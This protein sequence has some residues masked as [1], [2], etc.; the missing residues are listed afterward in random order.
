MD[1][2]SAKF[3]DL[4]KFM[5]QLLLVF[6]HTD[7]SPENQ[8]FFSSA[9]IIASVLGF[10]AYGACGEFDALAKLVA[11]FVAMLSKMSYNELNL[12]SIFSA[13]C[14]SFALISFII[15]CLYIERQDWESLNQSLTTRPLPMKKPRRLQMFPVVWQTEETKAPVVE[16]QWSVLDSKNS[17]DSNSQLN[18]TNQTTKSR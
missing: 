1:F 17:V 16:K 5:V 10:K 14:S 12:F 18:Q 7:I 9:E 3:K 11:V 8:G 13:S 15:F 6:Y 2:Q 4:A